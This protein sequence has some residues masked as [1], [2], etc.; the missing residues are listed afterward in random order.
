[1]AGVGKQGLMQKRIIKVVNYDPQWVESYQV[2]SASIRNALEGMDVRLHHIG[3]TS[4]PGL[5][6]KPVIDILI[7]VPDV[8]AIEGYNGAMKAIGYIPKGEFG[9]AGRRFYLKGLYNRTHH[10]HAFNVGTPD[11]L[12]HLAFRDYL[13]AHPDI[14]IEYGELK[15]WVAD[16]CDNDNDVYC[17]GKSDFVQEHEKKALAWRACQ[18]DAQPGT[19]GVG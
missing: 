19:F 3:S 16:V 9:I 18:F 10:I 7:E 12:R 8:A 2:E 5:M 17:A 14:A 6:A 1:M 13:I 11:V 4:V 15:A